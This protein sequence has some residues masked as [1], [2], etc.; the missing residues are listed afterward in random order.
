MLKILGFTIMRKE[1]NPYYDK[2]TEEDRIFRKI[3][4][5]CK[6]YTLTDIQRMFA[7]YNAVKYL[8]KADIKGDF[9]ECGVWRGGSSMLMV[10]TLLELGITDRKIFLY[11][12]FEGMTRPK[13]DEYNLKNGKKA[14]DD[15]KENKCIATIDE[16]RKNM[17]KTGYPTDNIVFV[18]GDVLQTIPEISPNSIALLRL[19]TDWYESTRH[20]LTHLYPLLNR[21]GVLI[22]DDYDAWS[23]SK[24]AT[25]EYFSKIPILLNRIG[26]SGRIAIKTEG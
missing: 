22:I 26:T 15:Y 14:I 23:G 10:K 11:D 17:A 21:H 5:F 1:H 24:K 18:K 4:N 7:L 12:T 6:D 9:V 25:D 8:V 16:V 19:D 3:Y 2:T 20:E 13:N